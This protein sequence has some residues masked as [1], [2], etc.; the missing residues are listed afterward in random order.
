MSKHPKLKAPGV[1]R[2]FTVP[3]TFQCFKGKLYVLGPFTPSFLR[4]QH[5][6]IEMS[7]AQTMGMDT[8]V[9]KMSIENHY[10]I[11]INTGGSPTLRFVS[12]DH[13]AFVQ[14]DMDVSELEAVGI[15]ARGE[16]DSP[17]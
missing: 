11:I 8:D 16:D 13:V 9:F 12:P 10:A 1:R 2:V 5:A 7:V 15:I 6:F 17:W 4:S 3:G 14:E